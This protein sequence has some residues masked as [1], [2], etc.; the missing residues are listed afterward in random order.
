MFPKHV[1]A[2][3]SNCNE[4]KAATAAFFMHLLSNT[5]SNI[6]LITKVLLQRGTNGVQSNA[7]N[8]LLV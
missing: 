2:I 7:E 5:K 6:T 1:S 4:D 8:H 3:N